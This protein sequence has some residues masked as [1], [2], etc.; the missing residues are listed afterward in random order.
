[1]IW[2]ASLQRYGAVQE[3]QGSA[4][5]QIVLADLT[6]ADDLVSQPA[7]V[8]GI[9]ARYRAVHNGELCCR[10]WLRKRMIWSASLQRY[11]AVQE[12]QCGSFG[13]LR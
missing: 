10:I 5:W 6:E 9:I 1:M 12:V 11:A 4:K 8:Q 3:V 13:N 2:S 7:A